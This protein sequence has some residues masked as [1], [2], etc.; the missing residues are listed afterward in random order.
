MVRA[1]LEHA[2]MHDERG[3]RSCCLLPSGHARDNIGR[4]TSLHFVLPSLVQIRSTSVPRSPSDTMSP[5]PSPKPRYRGIVKELLSYIERLCDAERRLEARTTELEEL[6][7]GQRKVL[8]EKG[9]YK[10]RAARYEVELEAKGISTL[11]S[12]LSASRD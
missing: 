7:D 5:A 3:L 2:F 11:R 1:S 9:L 8:A 4:A 12:P 10:A 6:K